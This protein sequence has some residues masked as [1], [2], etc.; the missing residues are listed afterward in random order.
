M[1]SLS[2]LFVREAVAS[3]MNGQ[4]HPVP[5]SALPINNYEEAPLILLMNDTFSFDL[6]KRLIS[7]D[8]LQEFYSILFTLYLFVTHVP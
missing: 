3:P 5:T 6:A 4:R 1:S 8:V 7:L 2:K